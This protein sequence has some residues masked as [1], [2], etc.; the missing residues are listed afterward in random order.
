MTTSR[1]RRFGRQRCVTSLLPLALL[2]VVGCAGADAEPS[3]DGTAGEIGQLLVSC[4]GP[5]FPR[6]ALSGPVGAEGLDDPAAEALRALLNEP[7]LDPGMLPDAGWRL[8]R[9]DATSAVFTADS[10]ADSAAIEAGE[11]PLWVVGV[12]SSGGLWK[13]DGFGQCNPQVELGGGIHAGRWAPDPNQPPP[14]RDASQLRV[15]VE[16]IECSS[17][18]PPGDRVLPPLI[19]YAPDAITIVAQLQDLPPGG[20]DCQGAPGTPVVFE[21]A[22]PIGDRMLLDGVHFPALPPAL[23]FPPP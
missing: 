10:N 9:R 12:T 4:S 19:D 7:G 18:Q 5:A 11:P 6:Q 17:G 3:G 22:A 13:A 16:E 20:Y 15:I 23:M 1:Q 14:A 2:A 21:L 8:V